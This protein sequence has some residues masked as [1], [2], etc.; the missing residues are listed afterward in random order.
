MWVWNNAIRNRASGFASG[1]RNGA[2]QDVVPKPGKAGHDE[3]SHRE[4]FTDARIT[5]PHFSAGGGGFKTHGG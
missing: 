2:L 4:A 1:K 5:T 3:F